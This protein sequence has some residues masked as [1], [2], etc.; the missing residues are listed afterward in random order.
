MQSV[1]VMSVDKLLKQTGRDEGQVPVTVSVPVPLASMSMPISMSVSSPKISSSHHQGGHD[2]GLHDADED[3]GDDVDDGHRYGNFKHYYEYHT[4]SRDRFKGVTPGSF[5]RLW[6]ELRQPDTFSILDIGCNEGDLTAELLAMVEAELPSSVH[7]VAY[8]LDFDSVLISVACERH[9]HLHNLHFFTVD[10]MAGDSLEQFLAEQELENTSVSLVV[11]LRVSM[12]V[13]LNMGDD[14]LVRLLL[15]LGHA[16]SHSAL[17]LDPQKYS[18]YKKACSRNAKLGR[19]A[20]PYSLEEL[21]L[22]TNKELPAFCLHYFKVN[23]ELSIMLHKDI[24]KWGGTLLFLM[25]DNDCNYNKRTEIEEKQEH[26]ID[27]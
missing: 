11:C 19:P 22:N 20:F 17:L 10:V 7:C 26:S 9:A 23:Y 3:D 16:A 6:K 13:H 8:G 2:K 4:A 14:G 15:L 1:S 27:N 21:R 18:Y 5:L 25:K 24:D 12:W